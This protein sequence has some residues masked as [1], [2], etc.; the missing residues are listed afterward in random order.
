MKYVEL[1]KKCDVCF[2][3]IK[4]IEGLLET[5]V[6]NAEAAYKE[7]GYKV[8]EKV[9]PLLEKLRGREKEHYAE[10]VYCK[11]DM[12]TKIGKQLLKTGKESE[13]WR[14]SCDT[15]LWKMEVALQSM[16][17]LAHDLGVIFLECSGSCSKAQDKVSCVSLCI[18]IIYI[19]LEKAAG[20][21]SEA[22]SFWFELF[23][24]DYSIRKSCNPDML[25]WRGQ[26]VD[27]RKKCAEEAAI[28]HNFSVFYHFL[29]TETQ[30]EGS[31]DDLKICPK[32]G[33]N[34]GS[35]LLSRTDNKTR[36]CDVCGTMEA[37][38]SFLN[39]SGNQSGTLCKTEA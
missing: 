25:K 11:E 18:N 6:R 16:W 17:R 35:C 9:Q 4:D 30:E 28:L 24:T 1:K 23:D 3:E 39:Y 21:W 38:E 33:K 2:E 27:Y 26:S 32:C 14:E 31:R 8:F 20:K 36:I 15:Y 22:N 19:Y 29:P 10:V 12:D 37:L 5:V 13:F 7:G 34:L